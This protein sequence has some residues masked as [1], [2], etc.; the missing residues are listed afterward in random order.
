MKV[1]T[2][3]EIKDFAEKEKAKFGTEIEMQK[4]IKID[5]LEMPAFPPFPANPNK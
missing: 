2:K 1:L 5:I 4:G 3:Q